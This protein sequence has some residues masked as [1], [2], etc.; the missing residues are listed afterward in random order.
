VLVI[1]AALYLGSAFSADS[2]NTSKVA[3]TNASFKAPSP[4]RQNLN[5]EWVEIANRGSD[6][7]DMKGWTLSGRRFSKGS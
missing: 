1:L 6:A 3:I 2:A 7:Q 5:E 4:E